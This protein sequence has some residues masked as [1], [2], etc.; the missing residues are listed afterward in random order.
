MTALDLIQGLSQALYV[1]VFVLATW[2]YLRDPT[3][4]HLDM[5]LFFAILA[6]F[7]VETRIVALLGVTAPL[8]FTDILIVTILALPYI[9]LRLVDDFTNVPPLLKRA[10][11]V[12]ATRLAGAGAPR[13]PHP[14]GEPAAP[15]N[16]DRHRSRA[17]AGRGRRDGCKRAHRPLAGGRGGHPLLAGQQRAIGHRPGPAHRR[18]RV[19]AAT[20][21]LQRRPDQG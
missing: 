5:A 1:L 12:P 13:P 9:L 8:W 15:A 20:H 7:V 6:F 4:A 2:R 18:S 3:P 21:A 17:R 10:T 14:R 16:D 11:A 19:R